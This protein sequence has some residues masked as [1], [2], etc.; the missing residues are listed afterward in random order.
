MGTDVRKYR[1]CNSHAVMVDPSSLFA[2]HLYSHGFTQMTHST[3]HGELAIKP[4]LGHSN[5][6]TTV[7]F[8]IGSDI[9]S[10]REQIEKLIFNS[11]KI[12]GKETETRDVENAYA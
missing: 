11:G 1:F 7:D 9:G 10:Q 12:V 8:Y 2:I 6:R 4:Q 5:I 3:A